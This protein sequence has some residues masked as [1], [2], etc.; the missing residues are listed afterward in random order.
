[1]NANAH[2]TAKKT[3]NFFMNLS[4]NLIRQPSKDYDNQVVKN[5]NK[6][7]EEISTGN[8]SHQCGQCITNFFELIVVASH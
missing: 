5:F 2:K 6:H 3:E 8:E 7:Q 1:M 4:Q